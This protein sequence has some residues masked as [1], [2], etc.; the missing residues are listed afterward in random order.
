ML[1]TLTLFAA[2]QS[3]PKSAVIYLRDT[4]AAYRQCITDQTVA[5]GAANNESAETVLRGVA[6]SC[7]G[8]ED[9]LRLAHK[10]M[11]LPR[12]QLESS[13]ARVRRAAEDDGIA[14]LLAARA[15]R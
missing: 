2:L 1:L 11:M 15:K 10:P 12:L 8:N 4:A 7:R 5:L 3:D 9:A 14:A 13:I 6:A